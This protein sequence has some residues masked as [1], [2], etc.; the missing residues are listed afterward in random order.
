MS[1]FA[2]SAARSR[3]W[4]SLSAGH[5]ASIRIDGSIW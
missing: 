2:T 1:L 4:I 5:S 3:S